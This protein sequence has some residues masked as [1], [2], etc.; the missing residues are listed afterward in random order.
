[1]QYGITEYLSLTGR[2]TPINVWSGAFMSDFEAGGVARNGARSITLTTHAGDRVTVRLPDGITFPR[3][4]ENYQAIDQ[5]ISEA[6]RTHER[7]VIE[8]LTLEVAR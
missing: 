1:M 2:T 8:D 4:D 3:T 5:A 7:N 6:L